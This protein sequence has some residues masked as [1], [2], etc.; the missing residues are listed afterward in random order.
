MREVG[1]TYTVLIG[2]PEGKKPLRRLRRR[3][4]DNV[5]MEIGLK[6]VD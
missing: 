6:D 3:W 2:N 1:N 5:K 4:E